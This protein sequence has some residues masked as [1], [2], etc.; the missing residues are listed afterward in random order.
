M[1]LRDEDVARSLDARM[2]EI[3]STTEAAAVSA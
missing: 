2:D 1:G 3:R